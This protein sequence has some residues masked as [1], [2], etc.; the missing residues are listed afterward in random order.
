MEEENKQFFELFKETRKE[1]ADENGY[2]LETAIK[3]TF[4][5]WNRWE[6]GLTE[7]DGDYLCM[8]QRRNECG[9]I[10]EYQQVIECSINTW[11]LKDNEKVLRWKKLSSDDSQ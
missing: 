4:Q 7:F 9:T 3:K 11:I 5:K 10:S 2:H 1:I 6:T 8:I